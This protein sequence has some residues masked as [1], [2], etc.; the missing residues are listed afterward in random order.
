[1]GGPNGSSIPASTRIGRAPAPN[2]SGTARNAQHGNM[3]GRPL[4][5]H[6]DWVAAQ[7]EDMQAESPM[8]LGFSRSMGPRRPTPRLPDGTS[9]ASGG[10]GSGRAARRGASYRP[11][12]RTR[13]GRPQLRVPGRPQS[14]PPQPL[15]LPPLPLAQFVSTAAGPDGTPMQVCRQCH[16]GL[17]PSTLF[18]SAFMRL[19]CMLCLQ[20]AASACLRIAA[21]VSY[22]AQ[23]CV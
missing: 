18:I 17:H 1:M 5:M 3:S 21:P 12:H 7:L 22:S 4:T 14:P 20:R 16:V 10:R 19:Q 8:A 9:P 11:P 13:G 15:A 2:A 6:E 23:A